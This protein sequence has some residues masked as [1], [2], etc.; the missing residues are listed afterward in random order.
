MQIT[1]T[2]RRLRKA[3]QEA[4]SRPKCRALASEIYNAISG[5]AEVHRALCAP[6]LM[7]AG[8]FEFATRVIPARH[9]S[10]DFVCTVHRGNRVIAVVGDLM[11]KGLSAAMWITHIV[12]LIHRA[13]ESS[14]DL[15]S[16]LEFL[17][18]ELVDS[19]VGAPLTTAMALELDTG[20]NLLSYS[21]AGHPPG[22]LLR[23]GNVEILPEGGPILGAFPN[24]E[25]VVSQLELSP[26]DT[27][28]GYSDGISEARNPRDEEFTTA[29]IAECLRAARGGSAGAHTS[30]LLNAVN[31][32]CTGCFP[33]DVSILAVQRV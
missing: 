16:M 9:V 27:L 30:N 6:E 12:D 13:A 5:A 2:R 29:G 31:N 14:D 28:I 1:E 4:C 3:P 25:F 21:S 10:G 11:G 23:G 19:R 24:A 26:G 18:S 7:R 22:M 20:T 8:N 33:D 17:N 15:K 32:F